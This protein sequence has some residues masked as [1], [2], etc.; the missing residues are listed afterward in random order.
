MRAIKPD[1]T[2]HT[3]LCVLK[4][5]GILG[6]KVAALQPLGGWGGLYWNKQNPRGTSEARGQQ[7]HSPGSTL[8]T[9]NSLC[10]NAGG[11]VL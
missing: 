8:I 5:A 11:S 4:L 9:P 1:T 10:E 6:E 2:N 7:K 3:V